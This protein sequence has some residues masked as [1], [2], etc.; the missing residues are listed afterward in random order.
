MSRLLLLALCGLLVSP[1]EGAAQRAQPSTLPIADTL[2]LRTRQWVDTWNAQDVG[3][4]RRLHAADVGDQRYVIGNGFMTMEWLLKE[5]RET[6][7]WNGTWSLEMADTKVRMLGEDAGLVSFRLIGNQTPRGGATR[8]FSEAYSLI[9]QRVRGEWLIVHIH[10]SERL[11][12]DPERQTEL[13]AEM[14]LEE[15]NPRGGID[16]I[17]AW[18]GTDP[19][20]AAAIYAEDAVVVLDDGTVYRGREEI[21]NGWLR[22]L[23]PAVS[24]LTPSIEQVVGGPER[25]TLIGTYTARISPSDEPAFDGCGIFGNTWVRQPDGSWKLKASIASA[26]G[27]TCK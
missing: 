12:P 4:M 18:N 1:I 19:E 23:V 11:E 25:M 13:S 8:P 22:S 24:N 9:F 20:L 5:I 15:L 6:N 26:P 21:L 2:L 3:A 17:R 7:F 16:L 10:D 14:L 27:R